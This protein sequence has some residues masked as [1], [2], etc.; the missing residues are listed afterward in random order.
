MVLL[1]TI[2]VGVQSY[3]AGFRAFISTWGNRFDSVILVLSISIILFEASEAP[4]DHN[5]NDAPIEP[6]LEFMRGAARISRLVVFAWRLQRLLQSPIVV[7]HLGHPQG[8]HR[9]DRDVEEEVALT[10]DLARS[11]V[12][13]IDHGIEMMPAD[14]PQPN[15]AEAAADASH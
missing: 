13:D 11:A 6:L 2:E 7:S 12:W 1:F 4:A 8:E 5:H 14:A 3:V 9:G 10:R 15:E